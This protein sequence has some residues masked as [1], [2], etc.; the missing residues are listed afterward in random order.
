MTV[1]VCVPIPAVVIVCPTDSGF[2]VLV[3]MQLTIPSHEGV[4]VQPKAAC[5]TEFWTIWAPATGAT[6]V[7]VGAAV[8]CTGTVAK[9][10][11]VLVRFTQH[12]SFTV[13]VRISLTWMSE[14]LAAVVGAV[15]PELWSVM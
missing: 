15:V 6:I 5:T 8:S 10:G 2:P 14:C 1:T 12:V 13:I 11:C 7:M 9:G 3:A 4:W